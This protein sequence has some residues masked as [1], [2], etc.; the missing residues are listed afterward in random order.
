MLANYYP[1]A[2]SS[3]RFSTVTRPTCSAITQGSQLGYRIQSD[4]RLGT[5]FHIGLAQSRLQG[6]RMNTEI[7]G[8]LLEHQRASFTTE[9][10]A[11]R[12]STAK[13]SGQI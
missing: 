6:H 1:A 10:L 4:A 12:V 7:A 5:V 3:G 9:T 11:A 13:C 2:G 8:D